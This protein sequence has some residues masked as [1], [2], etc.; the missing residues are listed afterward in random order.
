MRRVAA[1]LAAVFAIVALA[2]IALWALVHF[3]VGR[4]LGPGLRAFHTID[5]WARWFLRWA[6]ALLV[7]LALLGRFRPVYLGALVGIGVAAMYWPFFHVTRPRVD[8]LRGRFEE[9]QLDLRDMAVMVA[10]VIALALLYAIVARRERVRAL[11]PLLML[12]A[13]LLPLHLVV[14]VVPVGAPWWLP[15]EWDRPDRLIAFRPCR[16]ALLWRIEE[17]RLPQIELHIDDRWQRFDDPRAGVRRAI[18]GEGLWA[19][20]YVWLSEE[21]ARRFFLRSDDP[22]VIDCDDRARG[23]RVRPAPWHKVGISAP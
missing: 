7:L 19:E 20:S 21:E 22:R 11:V 15:G 4:E 14:I 12:C 1:I 2:L 17:G 5:E 6:T 23:E 10:V 13:I 9:R 16:G 8:R 3:P 18:S